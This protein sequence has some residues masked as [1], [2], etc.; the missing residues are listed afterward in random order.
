MF[1]K[2][3]TKGITNKIT[4]SIW[5]LSR[6]SIKAFL[7]LNLYLLKAYPFAMERIA[8]KTTAMMLINKLLMK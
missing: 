4:G 1:L 7:P 3:R 6:I 2:I 5:V 8:I